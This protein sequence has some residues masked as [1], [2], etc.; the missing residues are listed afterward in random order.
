MENIE[1]H[2]FIQWGKFILISFI[3]RFACMSKTLINLIHITCAKSRE[4]QTWGNLWKLDWWIILGSKF[5]KFETRT[6]CCLLIFYQAINLR[7]FGDAIPFEVAVKANTQALAVDWMYCR[8]QQMAPK[9][10]GTKQINV[11]NIL[12]LIQKK[13]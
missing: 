4:Q 10:K 11:I 12:N 5:S 8:T 1:C 3:I 13:K 2:A 9:K 7:A 6:N